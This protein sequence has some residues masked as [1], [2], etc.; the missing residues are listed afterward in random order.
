MKV[1]RISADPSP[2]HNG[3][4]ANLNC[5]AALEPPYSVYSFLVEG[6]PIVYHR[7]FCVFCFEQLQLTTQRIAIQ[8]DESS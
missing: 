1:M 2:A 4:C 8:F 5:L 7:A 3:L 6:S